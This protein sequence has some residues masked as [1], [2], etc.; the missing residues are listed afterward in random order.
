VWR[1]DPATEIGSLSK[2]DEEW[3]D[4]NENT[5]M[6]GINLL[7]GGTSSSRFPLSNEQIDQL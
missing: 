2:G 6:A 3:I 5:L 7:H 1:L 4:E